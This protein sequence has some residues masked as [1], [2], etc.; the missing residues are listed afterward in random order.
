[1]LRIGI[2]IEHSFEHYFKVNEPK[3]Q[4]WVA[5]GFPNNIFIQPKLVKG[6]GKDISPHQM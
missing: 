4:V 1:M 5:I 3:K 6:D 2:S